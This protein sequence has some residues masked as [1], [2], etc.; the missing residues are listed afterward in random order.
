MRVTF[1]FILLTAAFGFSGCNKT[2]PPPA[3]SQSA[4]LTLKDGTV[5]NGTVTNSDTSAISL[6]TATG[7]ARTYPMSQIAQVSYGTAAPPPP[8]PVPAPV[9]AITPPNPAPPPPVTSPEPAP[10]PPFHPAAEFRTIPAGVTISVRTNRTIDSETADPGQTFSGV[11]AHDVA[12]N[13]GRV[14]IPRGSAATLIV[15]E[16]S[17][18]GKVQGRS[19]LAVDVGSVVVGGHTYRLETRDYTER[20]KEGVGTNKRTGEFLGGGTAL[21]GIIGAIAGGGKG[22]AI[23]ALSGAA[24]GGATQTLTRGKAV[25]IPA[26]TVLNFQL[27]ASIRIREMR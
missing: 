5:V 19:E 9:A 12:D 3:G 17:G 22:A 21:G 1:L 13:Q 7:E 8:P 11:V 23:G 25:R 27:E 16:A 24:A 6:R 10:V 26:E 14:A 18:Q 4:V 20:G 15:R 2:A